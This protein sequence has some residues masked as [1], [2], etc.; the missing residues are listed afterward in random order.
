MK[1]LTKNYEKLVLGAVLLL[2]AIGSLLMVFHVQDV[3]QTLDEQLDKKVSGKKKPLKPIDLTNGVAAVT[4]LST[5]DSIE[6]SGAHNTFNPV[7]WMKDKTGNMNPVKDPSGAVGLV[8][9]KAIPLPLTIS[10]LGPTGADGQYRYQFEVTRVYDKTPSKRRATTVSLNVGSKN[11]LFLLRDIKGPKDSAPEVVISLLDGDE[12]VSIS[13]NKPYSKTIAWAADL[14]YRWDKK[15][16]LGKRA[17]ETLNLGNAIY[18]IVAIDKDE[19][20]VS[21]PNSLRSV[22]KLNSAP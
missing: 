14:D 10:Y 13:T 11:D 7:T 5:H 22:I 17:G 12:T 6:L 9:T 18:K 15:T 20:V 4:H 19:V 21:A 16:F 3:R 8:Y 1:F 2:V